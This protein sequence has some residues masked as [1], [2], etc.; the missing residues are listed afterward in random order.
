MRFNRSQN[1]KLTALTQLK[2]AFQVSSFAHAHNITDVH[3]LAEEQASRTVSR[4]SF[5]GT[6]VKAGLAAGIGGIYNACNPAN[7]KTQPVIA[8][9]GAGIAG[10]HAAY[11]LKQAGF[12]AQVYEASGRVGGRIFSVTNAM[13]KGLWTEMGGEFIDSGHTDMLNLVKHFN[14]PTIDRKAPSELALKEYCY[15]FNK[16]L[17]QVK[18]ILEALRPVTKQLKRDIASLSNNIGFTNHT[19]ADIALDNM[20]VMQ[21]AEKL[22]INGWFKAFM[23][24][25]YTAE[26]GMDANEQSALNFLTLVAPD[27][28]GE[29]SPYGS[30]DE[31]FSV[32]G[33]NEKI[34]QALAASLNQQVNKSHILTAIQ[35]NNSGKYVLSFT[36][37]NKKTTDV[38]ADIVLIT[39]PFTVLR[40]VDIKIPLPAWKINTIKNLGYGSN[41]KIFVGVNQRLWRKQ[42]YGGY[43]F[44]DNGL[45]NGYDSTQM[46][47]NNDG[48]GVFVIAPG[49]K[50]GVEA[51]KDFSR[52][53]QESITQLDEIFPGVKEQF[54]G[55]VQYWNWPGYPFNKGSYMSYKAGQYTT[56][57][58]AQFKPVDSLYFAGEHCSISSQG[59]M[60]GAAETGRM[61]AEM[62]IKKLK[63]N[64]NT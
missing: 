64:I 59:F 32:A 17:Y 50:A 55:R 26:Y 12:T 52:M 1:N 35:Q 53:K 38:T 18:D 19:Q 45:M 31:R 24:N 30:S 10:L 14:L 16:T 62:I 42:G 41:S 54:N 27:E 48:P 34:C 5:T 40:D 3:G 13:G 37:D 43:T 22:G 25:C 56:M 23:Y 8:I 46:Q 44:T 36:D 29:F 61:A 47:N 20:T 6:V 4:R 15:Y 51:G 63:T 58:G 57:Q 60:N 11:I 2:K 28:K 9:V 33:G 39:I 49:G 7:K 21:Y